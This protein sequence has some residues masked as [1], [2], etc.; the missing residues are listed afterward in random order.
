M[1]NIW[2]LKLN[3][4][5]SMKANPKLEFQAQSIIWEFPSVEL[6]MEIAEIT[7]ITWPEQEETTQWQPQ[8]S[9]SI[10]QSWIPQMRKPNAS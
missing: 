1:L 10:S 3:N 6:E 2:N 8:G 9:Q 4:I 7:E 5:P